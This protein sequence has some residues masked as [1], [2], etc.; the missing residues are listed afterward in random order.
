[1]ISQIEQWDEEK[2]ILAVKEF[3]GMKKTS[4]RLRRDVQA[5]IERVVGI[6]G[7]VEKDP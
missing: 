4:S 3:L 5:S 7:P 2:I 6:D 1:M